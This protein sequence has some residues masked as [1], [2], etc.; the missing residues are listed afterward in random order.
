[1]RDM[2]ISKKSACYRQLSFSAVFSNRGVACR[3]RVFLFHFAEAG[4]DCF[5]SIRVKKSMRSSGW[6]SKLYHPDRMVTWQPFPLHSLL[7]HTN[8]TYPYRTYSAVLSLKP[9]H[10]TPHIRC[11]IYSV[12]C[13]NCPFRFHPQPRKDRGQ[14]R[15]IG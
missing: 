13:N 14:F 5:I 1:M 9:Q 7:Y 8:D 4:G 10:N 6:C 11:Q 15:S 12:G 2:S 3:C